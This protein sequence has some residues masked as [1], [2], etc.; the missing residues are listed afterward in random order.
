MWNFNGVMINPRYVQTVELNHQR[1]QSEG[2]GT[3]VRIQLAQPGF[4]TPGQEPPRC[5]YEWTGREAQQI[6][7]RCETLASTGAFTNFLDTVEAGEE[8]TQQA[9]AKKAGAGKS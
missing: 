7:K 8:R 1:T 4:T 2:G 6:R 5:V 9:A 3:C